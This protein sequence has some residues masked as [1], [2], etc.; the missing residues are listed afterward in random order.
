MIDRKFRPGKPLGIL[1]AAYALTDNVYGYMTKGD[2][3]LF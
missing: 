1:C 3:T 2:L